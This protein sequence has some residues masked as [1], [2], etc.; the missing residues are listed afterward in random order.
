V[1]ETR[2]LTP[3]QQEAVARD[4]RLAVVVEVLVAAVSRDPDRL[5]RVADLARFAHMSRRT[6]QRR[7]RERLGTTYRRF[8]RV[9]RVRAGGKALQDP[10]VG[11][12]GAARAGG[13]ASPASFVRATV[14]VD[15][16][17]P[18]GRSP[19]STRRRPRAR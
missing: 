4:S 3:E 16:V 7:F 14:K 1:P 5:P 17:T 10:S 2:L 11:E 9:L 8:Q 15:H 18:R 13:Y 12:K 19:R 6:L